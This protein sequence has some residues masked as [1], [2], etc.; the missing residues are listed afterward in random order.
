M[1]KKD[2]RID[3]Y[4]DKSAD[5][6]KPILRHLRAVVHAG[7]PDVEETLKWSHP[8]FMYKGILCGMASFK[9]HCAF[10]FWNT[11]LRLSI[12]ADRKAEEAMGQFGR[13]C[14]LSDLPSKEVL[15]QYVR[16]AVKLNEEGRKPRPKPKATE[17]KEVVVPDYFLAALRKKPKALAT[18]KDF[19][20]SNRK[21]YVE[22]ITEAKTE[23]TRKKRLETAIEWMSEGKPRNWKY[24][25]K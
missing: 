20:Y 17:K 24:M 12:T 18:F 6:A 5:F 16:E 8:S 14:K 13:I 11:E 1:G 10:G 15:V 21:E 19:S 9:N 7:C 3:A 4:I 2:A 22:W 23:E 25:R